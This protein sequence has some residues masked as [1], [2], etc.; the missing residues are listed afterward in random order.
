MEL[1]ILA[2]LKGALLASIVYFIKYLINLRHN[3][4]F[5]SKVTKIG[6]MRRTIHL[7]GTNSK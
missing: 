4:K 2:A 1:L 7:K 5:T 3:E 6:D